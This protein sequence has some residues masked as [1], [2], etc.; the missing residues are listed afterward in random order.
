MIAVSD[1]WKQKQRQRLAPE[2]FVELS[3][4]ISEDGLQEDATA[5]STDQAVF[6]DLDN[7]MEPSASRVY[8]RYATMELNQWCLDGSAE[9]LPDSGPYENAGY[10]SNSFCDTDDPALTINLSRV[11]T[12][13]IQGITIIWSTEFNEYN[14]SNKRKILWSK[15]KPRY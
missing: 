10:V 11:H 8:P 6:S 14:K 5:S 13:L 12:Q 7:V 1:A 4:L 9:I 2:G 15:R 3:Y